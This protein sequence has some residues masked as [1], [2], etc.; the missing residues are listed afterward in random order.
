[1]H[2][3]CFVCAGKYDFSGDPA[4]YHL[5]G[6]SWHADDAAFVFFLDAYKYHLIVLGCLVAGVLAYFW[7]LRR[8][9]D[10][11]LSFQDARL[12]LVNNG[13]KYSPGRTT[14]KLR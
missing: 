14:E 5:H 11:N 10:S 4:F 8:K 6:S 9:N 2:S 13:G 12:P 7:Y 1:V 3:M